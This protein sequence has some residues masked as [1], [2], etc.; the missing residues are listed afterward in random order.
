[1]VFD[2]DRQAL[3]VGIERRTFCH[4]P[5][6][7]HAIQLQPQ[8]VMQARRGMF[9]DDEAKMLGRANGSCP[10]GSA[11]F[12]KS[13]LAR[14]SESFFPAIGMHPHGDVQQP[15]IRHSKAAG[16]PRGFPSGPAPFRAPDTRYYMRLIQKRLGGAAGSAEI[17]A[18][19]RPRRSTTLKPRPDNQVQSSM[20]VRSS[21]TFSSL[22]PRLSL[23]IADKTWRA[24][25]SRKRAARDLANLTWQRCPD[26]I[27]DTLSEC[28][29]VWF[30]RIV[31]RRHW[32][33]PAQNL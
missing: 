5:G 12:V 20:S 14:Y 3:V 27:E 9:L 23:F 26:L 30:E 33:S 31:A 16:G 28:K 17:Y 6:L 2:F 13:R 7:E 32:Q 15:A 29:I 25:R 21:E 19:G 1:M 11:V 18:A 8:I 10:L 22:R 24:S 4:R